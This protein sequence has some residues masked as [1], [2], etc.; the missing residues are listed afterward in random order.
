M[1]GM[2]FIIPALLSVGTTVIGLGAA[3]QEQQARADA[4]AQALADQKTAMNREIAALSRNAANADREAKMNIKNAMAKNPYMTTAVE[5]VLRE[6]MMSKQK[7]LGNKANQMVADRTH[8]EKTGK[9]AINR[10]WDTFKTAQFARLAGGAVDVAGHAQK[11]GQFKGLNNL[12]G[13]G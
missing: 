8:L 4:Q 11:T 9:D 2:E 1:S 10:S 3:A 13:F 6:T 5:G 7:E 12:L